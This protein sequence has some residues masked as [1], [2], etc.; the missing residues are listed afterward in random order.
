MRIDCPGTSQSQNAFTLIES[1]SAQES[2]YE[3]NNGWGV[4]NF[5]GFNTP[6]P[7]TAFALPPSA[8]RRARPAMRL[9]SVTAPA[10]GEGSDF[11][12]RR[13]STGRVFPRAVL[14]FGAAAAA[15][16]VQ[17]WFQ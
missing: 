14:P 11:D 13:R 7:H 16:A 2:N 10:P 12:R 9:Q 3:P 5:V 1:A 8:R 17:A 6:F 4:A 15:I